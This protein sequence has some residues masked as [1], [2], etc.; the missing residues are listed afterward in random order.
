MKR[1]LCLLLAVLLVWM[2]TACVAATKA[3]EA[4]ATPSP[5][6]SAS[7]VPAATTVPEI[8]PAPEPQTEEDTDMPKIEVVVGDRAF[9]ATLNDTETT[10]ALIELLPLE[11]DM[12]ELNGNEKYFYLDS[13]LPTDTVRPG[14]IQAGDLMLYGDSCLVLFYKSFSSSYSY[15]TLGRLEDTDGLQEALGKGSVTVCFRIAK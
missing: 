1:T 4:T 2:F 6:P 12:S 7:P 11:I 14:S 3:P 5:V 8:T 9:A 10:R 15:T 13:S